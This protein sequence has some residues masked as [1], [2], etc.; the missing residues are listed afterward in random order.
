MKTFNYFLRRKTSALTVRRFTTAT[1]SRKLQAEQEDPYSQLYLEKYAAQDPFFQGYSD[2]DPA[3]LLPVQSQQGKDPIQNNQ[4]FDPILLR[5]I[6]ND[7][8]SIEIEPNLEQAKQISDLLLH[9]ERL[10]K[11]KKPS[12]II[13]KNFQKHR[14]DEQVLEINRQD[15]SFKRKTRFMEQ[16]FPFIDKFVLQTKENGEEKALKNYYYPSKLDHRKGVVYY[17]HGY[18]DTCSRYSYL[19]EKYANHGYDFLGFDYKGFG[20]SQ[21]I[22]GQI[23]SPRSVLDD[24]LRFME[25]TEKQLGLN[26]TQKFLVGMSFGARVAIQAAYER[27]D[28]SGIQLLAP[29][30]EVQD[31]DSQTFKTNMKTIIDDFYPDQGLGML[32]LK[33]QERIENLLKKFIASFKLVDEQMKQAQVGSEHIKTPTLMILGGKDQLISNTA[34]INY[35]KG[36]NTQDKDLIVYEDL[37]HLVIQDTTRF[38]QVS[39]DLCYWL[40]THSNL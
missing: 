4:I 35:F 28:I 25:V 34:A 16:K 38:E 2:V 14:T 39:K 40:Q 15:E 17:L 23:D 37:D 9:N 32:S 6:Y 5:D 19:A 33:K 30:I 29:Y 11:S 12:H 26:N 22:R 20:F 7:L 21:G 1:N 18:G 3:Q 10:N 24:Q 36:I 27:K 8:K 31:L 13:I